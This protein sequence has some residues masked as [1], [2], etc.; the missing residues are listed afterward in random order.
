M[1]NKT[2]KLKIMT[3]LGTRPE[4]IRLSCILPKMDKYFKHIIVY[5][6]QSYSQQ[7]STVFFKDLKLRKPDFVLDVKS[8]TLGGLLGNILK[9]AEEAILKEKPDALLV[10]GDTN[11]ALSAIIAKRMKIPIFHMEAGNRSFDDNVPEEINRRIVDHISDYNLAYTENSRRYLIAEGIHPGNIYVTGSP[12][13]EVFEVFIKDI[14]KSKI[15]LNLKL[16]EKE[17]FVVSIHREENVD[18]PAHLKELF[19]SLNYLAN[20]YRFPVIVS[21]HPRAKKRLSLLNL[22]LSPLIKLHEPFGFFDYNNLQ[23]NALCVLSDSGSI[24]EES[25]IFNF[26][27][28]QVR[29]SSERPE[30]FDAGSIILTGFNKDTIVSAVELVV[31]QERSGEIPEIPEGY[32]LKNVSSKVVKLIMGLS[33]IRKYHNN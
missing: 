21:Y 9:Q 8:E 7:L 18:N 31:N 10:L 29:V 1:R 12:L 28:I 24:P 17:Y 27:A 3:I 4:I 32:K 15:L 5:T 19:N 30:A 22:K 11:S 33:S 20:K 23:K 25:A 16:K 13:T 2:Q 14:E 6:S 26:R